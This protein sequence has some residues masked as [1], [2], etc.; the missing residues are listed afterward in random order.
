MLALAGG[1]HQDILARLEDKQ[2]KTIIRAYDDARKQLA[3]RMEFLYNESFGQGAAQP[4][5]KRVIEWA[6]NSELM[7]SIDR[8]M[9]S[10]GYQTQALQGQAFSA[11]AE[12]GWQ[13]AN[14]ELTAALPDFGGPAI[15]GKTVFGNLN[16]LVPDLGM[17]AAINDTQNLSDELRA[18]V[19]RELTAGAV[20]GEGIRKLQ[21]RLGV[22]LNGQIVPAGP[23]A[24][25][26]SR[27]AVIKGH[28][29]ARDQTFNDAGKLIPGLQ[30]MWLVQRDER[31]CPHCLGHWG[32]VVP[33]E[34]EFNQER[35]FDKTPPKVYGGTLEYPPLHPRCRC[36]IVAW[37]ERW[38]GLATNTPEDFQT[39]AQGA[40]E[41]VGFPGKSFLPPK[42]PSGLRA[43]RAG[44][45]VLRS[46]AI[47]SIPPAVREA[48]LEK[49]MSC[50]IG[51]K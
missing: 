33:V 7:G 30:K 28:N 10:L 35:T 1:R 21:A 19:H 8:H 41:A 25:L 29:A 18:A 36:T 2:A 15:V 9:E 5:P 11:G 23:R 49:F 45:A 22:V 17:A 31:T 42:A 4:E 13:Q 38:R 14:A 50:W 32:E 39:Q 34:N 3:A 44:R 51:G 47:K 40:A 26:I 20:L 27:W 48:T 12:L 46:Q 37:H 16:T 6:R 43:T 24:E